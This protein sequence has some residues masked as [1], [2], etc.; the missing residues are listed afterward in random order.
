MNICLTRSLTRV[1]MIRRRWKVGIP[2]FKHEKPKKWGRAC[3]L[4]PQFV[5]WSPFRLQNSENIQNQQHQGQNCPLFTPCST[6]PSAPDQRWLYSSTK[7]ATTGSGSNFTAE[8]TTI[9]CRGHS[10]WITYRPPKSGNK[11]AARTLHNS[12]NSMQANARHRK[13]WTGGVPA[14]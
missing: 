7:S 4:L 5:N 6:M 13:G 2:K 3:E 9:H 10:C 11:T 14:P 8:T 1:A 12:T